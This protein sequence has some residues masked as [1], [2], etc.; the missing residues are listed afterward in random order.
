MDVDKSG[1]LDIKELLADM[2]NLMNN[3]IIGIGLQSH[4]SHQSHQ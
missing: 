4:Q 2:R 1:T 3:N